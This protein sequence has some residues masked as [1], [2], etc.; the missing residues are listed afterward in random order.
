M[1]TRPAAGDTARGVASPVRLQHRQIDWREADIQLWE[2]YHT[3][4]ERLSQVVQIFKVS[5]VGQRLRPS[6]LPDELE[7]LPVSS[8][9][10]PVR[11]TKHS[12]ALAQPGDNS[13]T[14]ALPGSPGKSSTPGGPGPLPRLLQLLQVGGPSGSPC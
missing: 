9:A 12:E 10:Q 11:A 3:D 4:S 1:S 7:P 14:A 6:A 8:P 2:A 5:Y 13:H